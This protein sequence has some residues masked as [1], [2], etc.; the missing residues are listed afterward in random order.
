MSFEEKSVFIFAFMDQF[1]ILLFSE[2]RVNVSKERYLC[3]FISKI[4]KL[5]I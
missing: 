5:I 1:V 2:S 3:I 4:V